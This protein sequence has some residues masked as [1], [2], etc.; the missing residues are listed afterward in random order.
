LKSNNIPIKVE[1]KETRV[2]RHLIKRGII[3]IPYFFPS[4]IMKISG[5]FLNVY[6]IISVISVWIM[7]NSVGIYLKRA[8]F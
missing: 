7:K 8:L 4:I 1:Q 5:S 3:L 6:F 2:A